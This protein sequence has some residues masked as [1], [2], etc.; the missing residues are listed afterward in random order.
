MTHVLRHARVR[1]PGQ[2]GRPRD[3]GADLARPAR[4]RTTTSTATTSSSRRWTPTASRP[5]SPGPFAVFSDVN[6]IT[7]EDLARAETISMPIVLILLALLIFGSLVAAAMPVL[8]GAHRGGRRARRGPGDH[9]SSPRSRSSRSTSSRCSGIGLA[10][11][12]ALFVVSRFREEL[13]LL[14]G[15]RPGRVGD[16][17]SN[18]PWSPPAAPCC[19]PASPSP[20]RCRSLLVFPQAFLGAWG[21][22]ASR[23]SLVAMLAALTVLPAT[24]R[25][26]GRRIDAGRLPWRRHRPVS[27]DDD[28]GGWAALA[29]GV[30][31]RPVA[32]IVVTVGAP[33]RPRLAVPRREVGQRRLP[34]A[35]AGRAGA[36]RRGQ[37][38]RGVR[39]PRARRA[40][41]LLEGAAEAD[42]AAYTADVEAVDG[43]VGVAAGRDRGRQRPCC[44]RSWDGQQPDRGV[45]GHG[46]GPARGRPRRAATALVGGPTADTVDLVARSASHLPW[47][48]LIVLGVMLVLLFLAFG[49]RGA[50]DQGGA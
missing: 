5:T 17:R 29:R 50:A 20:R 23:P 14:P 11:D 45:A 49:S 32:V 15:R 18:A 39:R 33:A 34:G 22:A 48:G 26:L 25:L 19:S 42:V 12:Y 1:R 35:A 6:E 30:M 16:R 31:R 10:I 43:V 21:T 2:R 4:A 37:A 3:P 28:H 38:Q 7:S 24:L 46:R 41:L 47:M 13:A 27:V 8:V 36:R 9:R 44:A 40:S